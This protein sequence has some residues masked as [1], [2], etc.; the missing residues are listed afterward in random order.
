MFDDDFKHRIVPDSS[1]LIVSKPEVTKY[2][3]FKVV[4]FNI[5]HYAYPMP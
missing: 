5:K 4:A 1:N 2:L 3:S